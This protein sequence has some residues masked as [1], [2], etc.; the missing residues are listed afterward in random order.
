MKE[1]WHRL[2]RPDAINLIGFFGVTLLQATGSLLVAVPNSSGKEVLLL[3]LSLCSM[4]PIAIIL[5]GARYLLLQRLPERFRPLTT[6]IVFEIACIARA[7][8]F[9][10]LLLSA[11]FIEHSMFVYRILGS[12]AAIFLGLIV[13]ASL[14]TYAREFSERN[15]AL[16]ASLSALNNAYEEISIRLQARK[17]HLINS[18]RNQLTSGLTE[19]RGVDVETDANQLKYLLDDVVRPLSYQLGRGFDSSIPEVNKVDKSQVN[20]TDIYSRTLTSN[21]IQPVWFALWIS[22]GAFQLFLSRGGSQIFQALITSLLTSFCL[23]LIFRYLW[24]HFPTQWGLTFRA[25]AFSLFPLILAVSMNSL[26]HVLFRIEI[27][28]VPLLAAEVIYFEAI[29]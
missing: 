10:L 29:S 5:L 27:V 21:P 20:W 3:A 1:L 8:F 16:S 9:D 26:V 17:D 6:L 7:I 15:A 2:G 28:T 13:S 4:A 14:V 24:N 11:G 23:L 22:L 19:L 25:I 12:Q 18:I